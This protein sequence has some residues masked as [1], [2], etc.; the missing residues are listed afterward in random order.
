MHGSNF[1]GSDVSCYKKDSNV[2]SNVLINFAALGSLAFTKD[3]IHNVN[4]IF[5]SVVHGNSK[6]VEVKSLLI[7]IYE[8]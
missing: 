4:G 1:Y 8:S 7:K 3:V 2:I 6:N 5:M